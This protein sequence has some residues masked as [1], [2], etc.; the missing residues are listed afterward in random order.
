MQK[1]PKLLII[2]VNPLPWKLNGDMV[3]DSWKHI[4]KELSKKHKVIFFS[5]S[6]APLSIK[7]L[8]KKIFNYKNNLI[9]FESIKAEFFKK[10]HFNFLTYV[11]GFGK[12]VIL[13]TS[14]PD[15]RIFNLIGWK[16]PFYVYDCTDLLCDMNNQKEDILLKKIEIDF[17]EKCDLTFVNSKALFDQKAERV[18][19]NKMYEVPAGFP[20]NDYLL[21]R[22]KSNLKKTNQKL[23]IFHI[24]SV[25]FRF[26][27]ELLDYIIKNNPKFNF[28]FIGPYLNL[29]IDW[30]SEMDSVKKTAQNWEKI[31]SYKNVKNFGYMTRE[32]ISNIAD[33]LD[34]G[35]IPYE[36]AQEFNLYSNPVKFYDYLALGKPV[37]S[38]DI[39]ELR[40]Y[41]GVDNIDI[42]SSKEEFNKN[43]HKNR[44][45]SESFLQKSY[46]IAKNNNLEKKLNVMMK[47]ILKNI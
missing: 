39:I 7:N 25:S 31:L 43:L 23:T 6:E 44:K 30:M 9:I 40:K 47:E 38:T 16:K 2:Y 4:P 14:L 22:K 36:S 41:K 27:F 29:G 21:N 34:L 46:L 3:N 24:G 13:I 5:F 15:S 32:E 28:V 45:I 42:C 37:V 12:K 8:F 1:S 26:D 19:K 17:I 10:L 20:L 11:L 35:I 33:K 18:I